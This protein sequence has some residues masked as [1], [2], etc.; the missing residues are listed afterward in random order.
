MVVAALLLEKKKFEDV[1]GQTE[2]FEDESSSY[3]LGRRVSLKQ[4]I[5]M[6][7]FKTIALGFD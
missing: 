5:I 6:N 7:F 3:E 2:N 1:D 4:V